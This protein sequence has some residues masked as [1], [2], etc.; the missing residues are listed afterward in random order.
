MAGRRARRI[1]DTVQQG[2]RA[3]KMPGVCLKACNNDSR[4]YHGATVAATTRHQQRAAR[5][6]PSPSPQQR[7]GSGPA[8][9]RAPGPAHPASLPP[10]RPA[11]CSGATPAHTTGA[12]NTDAPRQGCCVQNP[13][14]HARIAPAPPPNTRT[15]HQTPGSVLR[16]TTCVCGERCSAAH[17]AQLQ[18]P[19][20][21]SP[22]PPPPGTQ[23]QTNSANRPS[24]S[25]KHT[26]KDTRLVPDSTA[27]AA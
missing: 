22:F 1:T 6:D 26:R 16:A 18:L 2:A 20:L 12:T 7:P 11:A 25:S 24:C 23:V 27:A 13:T 17:R 19:L 21:V 4:H 3:L 14:Q 5:P 9:N 10:K 15:G 8:T